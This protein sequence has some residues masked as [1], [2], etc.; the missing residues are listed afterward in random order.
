MALLGVI[1][2]KLFTRLADLLDH[3]VFRVPL[4]D[5]L[6]RGRLVSRDDN[7]PES[8]LDDS[9][10]LPCRNRKLLDA[11][12]VAALTVKRQRSF[13]VVPLCPL[14]DPL[15]DRPEHLFVTRSCFRELHP[16]MMARARVDRTL[17][18]TRFLDRSHEEQ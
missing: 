1:P 2:L 11:G 10:V 12:S 14:V 4:H 6:D 16:T 5:A 13:D 18:H 3:E 17:C 15:V 7:E 8:L 9:L